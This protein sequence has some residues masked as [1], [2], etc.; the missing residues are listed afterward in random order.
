[1][2][3]EANGM[4]F[5]SGIRTTC[6]SGIVI[7]VARSLLAL[8]HFGRNPPLACAMQVDPDSRRLDTG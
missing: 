4:G 8:P 5:A 2:R 6:I 1:M 7:F 3:L